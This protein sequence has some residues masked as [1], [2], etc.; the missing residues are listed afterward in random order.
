MKTGAELIIE[1]RARQIE[2]EGFTAESDR[3][4]TKGEL[5][6]AGCCYHSAARLREACCDPG[7]PPTDWP[8]S[9]EYW[10]PTPDN[11]VKEIIKSG[12]LLQAHVDLTGSELAIEMVKVCAREIDELLN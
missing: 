6:Y 9:P 8:F 4:Y 1:E 10:K 5:F 2:S 3:Q 7:T 12:A 11:R